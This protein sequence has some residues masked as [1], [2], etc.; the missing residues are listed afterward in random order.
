MIESADFH[1]WYASDINAARKK[2]LDLLG[3]FERYFKGSVIDLGCGEGSMLLVLQEHGRTDLLGVESNSELAD[4]AESWGVP[5]MR[6]DLLQYVRGEQLKAATYVYTDV[7]E[8][9]PFEVNL[10]VM[11]RLPAGSRLI[12]QTPDTQT[13]RGHQCYFN[14]PSHVAPYSSHVLKKMLEGT[15]YNVV[16][17]GSV[18]YAYPDNW[19][20]KVRAFLTRKLTGLHPDMVLGGANY[21][22][23]ADRECL[24]SSTNQAPPIRSSQV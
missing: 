13:L 5:V 24:Q 3:K 7:V 10:E 8:H 15:G 2:G 16:A 20:R 12:I 1:C 9:V 18:D 11:K 22:V 19:Q 4:L 21:F 17:E 6:K 14:V 23:V